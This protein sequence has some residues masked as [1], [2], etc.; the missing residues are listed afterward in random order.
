MILMFVT[1]LIWLIIFNSHQ[2][3]QIQAGALELLGQRLTD[4][5]DNMRST[6]TPTLVTLLRE[7][8]DIL[9]SHPVT[10]LR[11]SAFYAMT[12]VSRTACAGEETSLL[13]ALPLILEA[14]RDQDMSVAALN[15]LVPLR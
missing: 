8:K 10:R 5:T 9:S 13:G 3:F 1:F 15:V 11:R 6:L 7:I 4:V 2:S 14:V 12:S